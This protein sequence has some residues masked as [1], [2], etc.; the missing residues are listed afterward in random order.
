MK[1]LAGPEGVASLALETGADIV[2]CAVVGM[3]GLRPVMTAVEAGM[4]V[5]LATKEVLVAAGDVVTRACARTG[6][7]LMPV[8]SEHSAIFQC[9]GAG[10]ERPPFPPGSLPRVD[11]LILTASGGPFWNRHD[12]DMR[13][14]TADAAL[15]HPRWKMGRKVTV[16]SATLM[17]KGLEIMEAG[18]LFGIPLERID[19]L[20]HPESIVHSLVRF[21]DGS[22]LAQLS[23]PDMRYAIQYALAFPDRPDGGL[24]RLR[25]DELGALRF[26]RTD[27]V[28]FPCLGLAVEA[29]RKGGTMPAVLNAA[30]EMAVESF[31]AG[32]LNFPGIWG[33]VAKVTDMHT[34]VPHP[35]LD[36]IVEADEWARRTARG[37]VR[38]ATEKK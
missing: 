13:A 5:A 3:A 2:V 21:A 19:T 37:I 36:E 18:W 31:L 12:M 34:P 27:P 23:P 14:I 8:D 28:R 35:G 6:A 10:S 11:R 9:L 26:S 30:N 20:I 32:H 15:E 7:R 25:L 33:T 4:D 1:V 24:P 17:N 29:A 16:D 38:C 22:V